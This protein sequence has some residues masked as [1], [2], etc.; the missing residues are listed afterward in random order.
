MP[1]LVTVAA[2]DGAVGAVRGMSGREYR[3][4][5]GGLYDMTPSD[6]RALVQ[7]GGF[8][9]S[10]GSP[11][12]GGFPCATCGFASLFKRCSKCGEINERNLP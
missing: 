8:R 2:P 4:R 11:R 9:P 7:A 1:E 10:L 5:R 3:A 12:S 6:A